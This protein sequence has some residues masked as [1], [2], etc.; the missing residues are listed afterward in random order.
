MSDSAF[1]TRSAAVSHRRRRSLRAD[2]STLHQIRRAV[3][4]P[5][6]LLAALL[7]VAFAIW[8]MGAMPPG[9]LLV[10]LLGGVAGVA[11]VAARGVRTAADAAET[12]AEERRAA[13][14]TR[15]IRTVSVAGVPSMKRCARRP[16][17]PS[18]QTPF[19]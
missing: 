11:L 13:V 5:L 19:G 4:L 18:H 7:G 12:A 15:H 6:L 16:D 10:G 8:S 17:E 3:I 1:P 2:A 9:W 14:L